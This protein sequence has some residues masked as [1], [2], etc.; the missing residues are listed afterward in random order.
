M[1]DVI[2]LGLHYTVHN[3]VL[4]TKRAKKFNEG[5]G[6]QSSGENMVLG[7]EEKAEIF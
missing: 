7:K 4:Y 5:A 2:H 6:I 1:F 3:T